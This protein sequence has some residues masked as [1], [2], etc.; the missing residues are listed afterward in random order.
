MQAGAL[1]SRGFHIV[2][3]MQ[4]HLHL[5]EARYRAIDGVM[6]PCCGRCLEPGTEGSSFRC[7]GIEWLSF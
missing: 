7:C 5:R 2:A 3:P 4:G 1:A 6:V